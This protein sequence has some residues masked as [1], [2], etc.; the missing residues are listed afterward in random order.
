MNKIYDTNNIES[1]ILLYKYH[2]NLINKK[3]SP[4]FLSILYNYHNKKNKKNIKDIKKHSI[5]RKSVT[6]TS[7]IKIKPI[8]IKRRQSSKRAS[9]M[10]NLLIKLN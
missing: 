9:I 3:I 10:N 8:N 6:Y 7:L 2:P 1:S 5:I 4:T